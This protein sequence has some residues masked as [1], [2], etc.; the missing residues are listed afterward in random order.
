MRSKTPERD[1]R[2]ED[3]PAT[4]PQL[5]WDVMRHQMRTV[6]S[7]SFLVALFALPL[8]AV[9]LVFDVFIGA[10][11][12]RG[13]DVNVIFSLF[14]YGVLIAI[15]CLVILNIGLSGAYNVAQKIS[16]GEGLL[17]NVAFYYGLKENWKKALLMSVINALSAALALLGS[18]FLSLYYQ[19]F[20]IIVGIGI[21][22]LIVQYLVIGI[23]LPYFFSQLCVYQNKVKA[24]LRNSLLF[25]LM[26]IPLN[27]ILFLLAPGLI[28]GL[29]M[30][31]NVTA[32]V[33]MAIFVFF[34]FIGVLLWNLYA[35]RVF[36]QYIN[37]EHYPEYV[38]KGLAKKEN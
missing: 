11:Y 14:F 12:A 25:T 27:T 22:L 21:G 16:F 28:I 30:I 37:R 34:N 13:D 17:V 20:P 3:L 6:V 23:M 33:A 31:N 4:R 38:N 26:K 1:F 35:N 36:D 24:T 7:T 8:F 10:A 2:P 15:P 18:A 9:Y 19:A 32:Y 5:F 29:A